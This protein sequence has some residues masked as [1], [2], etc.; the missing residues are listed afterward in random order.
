MKIYKFLLFPISFLFLTGS[1]AAKKIDPADTRMLMQPAISST[2]IAFVYAEDLW[3]AN[4]DGSNPHRLTVDEGSN[5]TR[6]FL[7]MEK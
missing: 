5:Q 1:L 2:H 7:R 4:K 3:I 6:F